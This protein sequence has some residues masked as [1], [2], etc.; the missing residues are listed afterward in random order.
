MD[1]EEL[2][3]LQIM[4]SIW[5]KEVSTMIT[6]AIL[7][8]RKHI[9]HVIFG[10]VGCIGNVTIFETGSIFEKMSTETLFLKME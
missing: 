9:W 10:M 8:D 2:F 3:L 1:V 5:K 4:V 7:D 6:I